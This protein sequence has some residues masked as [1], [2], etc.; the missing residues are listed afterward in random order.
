[1]APG[2]IAATFAAARPNPIATPTPITTSSWQFV[3]IRWL[4]YVAL[5]TPVGCLVAHFRLRAEETL[6]DAGSRHRLARWGSW[7]CFS[8]ALLAVARLW[9]QWM[10]LGGSEAGTFTELMRPMLFET[11]WGAALIAQFIA[12]L[13]A[14]RAFAA[15]SWGLAAA[16]TIII[17]ATPALSGHAIGEARPLIGATLDTIHVLAAG[18]WF[19]TLIV[20]IVIAI[21]VLSDETARAGLQRLLVRF[22]RVALFSAAILTLTGVYAAWTNIGSWHLLWSTTYGSALLRK[23]WAVVVTAGLGFVNWRVSVPGLTL[24]GRQRFASTGSAEMIAALLIFLFTAVLVGE[25]LP[26]E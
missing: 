3:L 22:S 7:S 24:G 26:I 6:G 9:A 18:A 5:A 8:L 4:T 20:L 13:V 19:G 21:P 23:L 2:N 12:A 25:P 1:M 17:S 11:L 16:A 14:S 10:T 15:G